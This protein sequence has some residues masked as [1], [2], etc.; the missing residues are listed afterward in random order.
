MLDSHTLEASIP[1]TISDD[2]TN[3]KSLIRTLERAGSNLNRI[4][5]CL[6]EFFK[7]MGVYAFGT[8]R[9][10]YETMKPEFEAIFQR[11]SENCVEL[12]RL[13]MTECIEG[14]CRDIRVELAH[15]RGLSLVQQNGANQT[16]ADDSDKILARYRRIQGLLLALMANTEPNLWDALDR[17][18]DLR[19]FPAPSWGYNCTHSTERYPSI[20]PVEVRR[21]QN[22]TQESPSGA[23]CWVPGA[24]QTG[25]S[26]AL[27]AKL[28][29]THKLGASYF[30]STEN[31][32]FNSV[33]PSIA[34][35]LANYSIPFQ[36]AL[37][38]LDLQAASESLDFQ[39][40]ELVAKPLARVREALP[41]DLVVVI[42]VMDECGSVHPILDAILPKSK[43]LPIK[44]VVFSRPEPNYDAVDRL[45]VHNVAR[46]CAI[47]GA[48]GELKT[49]L[50]PLGLTE[51]QLAELV[52]RAG[53]LFACAATAAHYTGYDT[54]WLDSPALLDN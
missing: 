29:A 4:V 46:E 50:T 33:I 21:L 12:T 6:E 3:L 24:R 53:V 19:T 38:D 25:I 28:D 40:Q 43:D 45:F 34:Y 11:L 13:R 17:N 30:F 5:G 20:R 32:D 36:L 14:L 8:R 51:L 2:W 27:C 47:Q 48:E 41:A 18:D 10:E 16:R 52:Q 49:A 22:W 9:A 54:P 15:V 7:L 26:R 1:S 23:V 37:L 39:F 44:F 42:D 31:H 35:Q